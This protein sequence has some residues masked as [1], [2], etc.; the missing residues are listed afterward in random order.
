LPV[1]SAA[2]ARCESAREKKQEQKPKVTAA[3]QAK[4]KILLNEYLR[5]GIRPKVVAQD[6]ARWR[7]K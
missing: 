5:S 6:A 4:K 2:G 7:R 1:T 3:E